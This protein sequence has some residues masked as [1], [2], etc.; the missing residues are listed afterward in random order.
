MSRPTKPDTCHERKP[1]LVVITE[2]TNRF[3][4][5]CNGPMSKESSYIVHI[6]VTVGVYVT[7]LYLNSKR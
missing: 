7:H 2:H 1:K 3:I 6:N 4:V 5:E